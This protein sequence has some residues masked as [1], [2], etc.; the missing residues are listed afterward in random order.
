[1]RE[2]KVEGCTEKHEAKGYCKKHY[3]QMRK[4]GAIKKGISTQCKVIGCNNTRLV[5]GYCS[6][7]AAQ[8]RLYGKIL[9][10][11]V[12]DRNEFILDGDIYKIKLYN[13][14][15]IEVA[16]AIIDTEDYDKCK[17]LKWYLTGA[18]YVMSGHSPFLHRLVLGKKR[19]IDHKDGNPL[20]NRKNNLRVCTNAENCRNAKL[21][22]SNTS[23]YKGVSWNKAQQ[24]WTADITFNYKHIY[25]GAFTEVEQA[26]IA[27][28]KKAVELYREFARLNII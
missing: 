9:D 11:T 2:C 26:A 17:A 28:N 18:G 22:A 1:M 14:K 16:E 6:R 23:G 4:Y 27:Y 10:R 19:R 20:N 12:H 13:M 21:S 5:K 15:N 24:K 3:Q 7:H 25:L 8:I